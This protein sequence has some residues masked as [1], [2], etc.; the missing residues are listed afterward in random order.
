[1]HSFCEIIFFTKSAK[2]ELK[3]F[4]L[5]LCFMRTTFIILFCFVISSLYAQNIYTVAGDGSYFTLG[6]GIPATSCAIYGSFNLCIDD[7][8]NI[9]YC[10]GI[11]SKI[12]KLDLNVFYYSSSVSWYIK[13]I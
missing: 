8:F 11:D 10:N 4:L 9:Y 13:F 3:P 12:K 1:M 2:Q 6:E 7:S 5:R